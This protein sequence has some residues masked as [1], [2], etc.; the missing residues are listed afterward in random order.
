MSRWDTD[1]IR[2]SIPP[3]WITGGLHVSD[4]GLDIANHPGH[5]GAGA[6]RLSITMSA[7]RKSGVREEIVG[8]S[9]PLRRA[10]SRVNQVEATDST[11]LLLGPTGT[12]K[13]LFA[14]AVTSAA[15][16]R[17]ALVASTAGRSRQPWWR[18]NSSGTREAR[19]PARSQCDRDDSSRRP[20]DDL[21]RRDWRPSPRM[22]VK[23]LRVLQ[24]REFERVGS[25][26]TRR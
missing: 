26:Q 21:P 18:A 22:Q 14:R 15:G 7:R 24:E 13:E 12:G 9:A 23:L 11:V 17:C 8:E 25:S 6:H 5:R 10:L 1:T 19:S 16:G 20:G 3:R 2:R 4:G